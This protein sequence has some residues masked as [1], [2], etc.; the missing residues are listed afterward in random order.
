MTVMNEI[1]WGKLAQENTSFYPKIF[2]NAA[3]YK[4]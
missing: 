2:C 1:L 4:R 3:D